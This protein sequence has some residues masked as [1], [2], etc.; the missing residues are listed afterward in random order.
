MSQSEFNNL[1]LS[2]KSDSL[3]RENLIQENLLLKVELTAAIKEIY[4][5]KNQILTDE[6]LN[7]L[8]AEHLGELQNTVYGVSSERY[9]KPE[10][11]KPKKTDP[12]PKIKKPSERYPNI[13]V[14]VEKIVFLSAP[15][16]DQCGKGMTDSGMF[17]ESEQLNVIPKKFEIIRYLRSKYRCSCQSCLKTAPMPPRIVPGSSY[18]DDMIIDVVCS[19]YCDLL[20]VERYV[21]MA[22]RG[23]LRDLP[24]H[25]LIELT[26]QFAHYVNPV[27]EL[28]KKDI[29]NS[30]VLHADETPHKMLEGSDTKSWYLW[31]FSNLKN[32]FLECHNTR[33]GDVASAILNGSSCEVLIS[34]VF[35]GYNK[36]I[37]VVNL[38]RGQND[39]KVIFNAKCN[40]HA[41][42]YFF[43]PRMQYKGCEFYLENYHQIYLLNAAAKG[44]PPDE[45]LKLR[46]QML[47]Y[48]LAMKEKAEAEIMS[49]QNPV[50]GKYYKALNY[51]LEN[52]EGLTYFLNY[53]DVA[54]DNNAQERLLRSHVVG[55]KTW[56]GTHSEKSADT[57]AVLFSIIET[58]KL[59]H[60]NPRE[61]LKNLVLDLQN[62]KNPYTPSEY[63]DLSKN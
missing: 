44:R 60:I 19:K 55:R 37:T 7:L 40:A 63:K 8:L 12:L 62:G 31:G 38:L 49:G 42:R 45:V 34:D 32:C 27:Y 48:F 5:L 56:Y 54:I 4:R 16:C 47:Q 20:P 29:Q 6:Q 57:A 17:E 35:G 14:R 22:G 39:E 23:G 33:S 41:R 52:Y 58:C 46:N 53:T 43:K 13:P 51:F 1:S 2:N 26:H 18:S 36:A 25:S 15:S 24:P 50:Q 11:T 10:N 30:R 61:Y 9:K 59:N 3:S 21:Q 28:I